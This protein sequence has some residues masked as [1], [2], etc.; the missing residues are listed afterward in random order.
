MIRF[1]IFGF[2]VAVHWFFWIIALLIGGGLFAQTADDWARALVMVPVV[3]IS[4]LVHELG[5]AF[6]GRHYHARPSILLHGLGGMA[7]LHGMR[8]N[9]IQ[10]IWVSAAGPAA[11]LAL[12]LFSMVLLLFVPIVH[13]VPM[14][15]QALFF[16]TLINFFWTFVNLLPIMPM[17]GGQILREILGPRNLKLAYQIGFAVAVGCALLAF[18]V[19]LYILA[20]LLGFLA[21][22]NLTGQRMEGGVVKH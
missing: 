19:N 16:C 14:L 3:F 15:Q 18:M 12:G 10:S 2:P 22:A 1:K 11:G 13:E 6:A 17:D 7:T 5:H 4:I 9:W 21:Y 20:I 8:A